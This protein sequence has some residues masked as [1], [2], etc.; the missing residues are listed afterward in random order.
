VRA[1]IVFPIILFAGCLLL[2]VG[3]FRPQRETPA[4]LPTNTDAA[5]PAMS[6]PTVQTVVFKQATP[7][8][9]SINLPV[10]P[11]ENVGVVSV[12]QETDSRIAS[13]D[14]LATHNDADSLNLILLSLTDSNP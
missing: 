6:K 14:E 3:W 4:I 13:L 1:R 10:T 5:L 8:S 9:V 7:Q 11:S 12:D 2:L